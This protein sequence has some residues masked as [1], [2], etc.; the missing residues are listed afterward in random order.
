MKV[1]DMGKNLPKPAFNNLIQF[2]KPTIVKPPEE[3]IVTINGI[4]VKFIP[5]WTKP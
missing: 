5:S 3:K 4:P 1:F 2:P